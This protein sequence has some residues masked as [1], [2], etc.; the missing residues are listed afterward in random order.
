[1]PGAGRK[2]GWE[3]RTV[4][5]CGPDVSKEDVGW[6]CVSE[7]WRGLKVWGLGFGSMG[8]RDWKYEAWGVGVRGSRV[9]SNSMHDARC[10]M[11]D[12]VH[13]VHA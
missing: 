12:D 11:H 3:S 9:V 5:V 10:S 1:M 7:Q 6:R 13:F 4:A 8:F 2:G